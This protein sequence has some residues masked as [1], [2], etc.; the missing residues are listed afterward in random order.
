MIHLLHLLHLLICI[1]P[2][3]FLLL[4]LLIFI[5]IFRLILRI[6]YTNK[7]VNYLKCPVKPSLRTHW[8]VIVLKNIVYK[9]C[10][11]DSN[12]DYKLN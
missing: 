3:L 1:L 11:K 2:V 10:K 5:Y 12:K 8:H 6:N 7:S 9:Y 4:Y